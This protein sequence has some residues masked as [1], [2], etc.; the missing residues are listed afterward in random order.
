MGQLKMD[1]TVPVWLLDLVIFIFLLEWAYLNFRFKRTQQGPNF[2]ALNFAM[3]PGFFL[4]LAFRFTADESISIFSIACL[5][6]SGLLHL[7][8]FYLR[9]LTTK[10]KD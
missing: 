7:V 3:A 10:A 2:L 5:F 4:I 8:D 1:Y 9:H 6:I